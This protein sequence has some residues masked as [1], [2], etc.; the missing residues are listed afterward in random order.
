VTSI[1]IIDLLNFL[2]VPSKTADV[3]K[4]FGAEK[5][6]ASHVLRSCSKMEW[7]SYN[8]TTANWTTTVRGLK[9]MATQRARLRAL[10]ELDN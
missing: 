5:H 6:F 3:C 10:G 8:R 4:R 7:V 1:R 9:E 2:T